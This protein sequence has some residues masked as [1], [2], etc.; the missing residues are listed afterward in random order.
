MELLCSK[1]Q[2]HYIGEFLGRQ[3][4]FLLN[5]MY[6]L[7]LPLF[8]ILDLNSFIAARTLN[9]EGDHLDRTMMQTVRKPRFQLVARALKELKF[10]FRLYLINRSLF[11]FF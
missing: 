2:I 11:G 5:L 7:S 4:G 6:S 8:S 10:L 3:I 9:F 1:L